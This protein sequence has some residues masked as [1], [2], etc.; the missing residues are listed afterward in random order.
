MQTLTLNNDTEL[1]NSHAIKT[2]VGLFLYIG[3][4]MIL[5]DVA[6][7]LYDPDT[8]KKIVYDNGSEKT[9]FRG[10]KKLISVRDEGSGLISATLKK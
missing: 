4:G 9:T 7:L 3:A 6:A 2:D 8:S 1:E 5:P 10:Y